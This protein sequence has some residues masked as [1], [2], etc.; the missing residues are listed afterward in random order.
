VTITIPTDHHLEARA[1]K[2]L[3][4]LTLEVAFG[5]A[6]EG[7][8]HAYAKAL[9]DAARTDKYLREIMLT[10]TMQKRHAAYITPVMVAELEAVKA[11]RSR[12]V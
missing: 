11:S 12:K 3:A 1:S 10:K 8:R 7:T 9:V 4:K 5:Q 6:S 2:E